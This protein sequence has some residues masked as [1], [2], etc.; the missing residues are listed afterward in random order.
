MTRAIGLLRGGERERWPR[1]TACR[2]LRGPTA[3]KSRGYFW[4]GFVRLDATSNPERKEV[5]S[6]DTFCVQICTSPDW[7]LR[8]LLLGGV[9]HT[10][11][12]LHMQLFCVS[13]RFSTLTSRDC[14]YTFPQLFLSVFSRADRNICAKIT[15]YATFESEH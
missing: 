5:E 10:N 6:M 2:D 1:C 13:H 8:P 9:S 15:F 11:V 7:L 14:Y 12:K 4:R 3:W